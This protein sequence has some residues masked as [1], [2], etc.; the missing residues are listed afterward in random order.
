MLCKGKLFER[1][2]KYDCRNNP[3]TMALF[4]WENKT[5]VWLIFKHGSFIS[6]FISIMK[7]HDTNPNDIFIVFEL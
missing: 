5:A 7:Y 1:T 3:K 4:S 6:S 2:G